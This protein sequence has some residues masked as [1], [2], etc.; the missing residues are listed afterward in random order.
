[1]VG[2]ARHLIYV[3][4]IWMAMGR[5][6]VLCRPGMSGY[7]DTVTPEAELAPARLGQTNQDRYLVRRS[8]IEQVCLAAEDFKPV[9]QMT[10]QRP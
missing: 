10:P 2:I 5:I 6:T 8:G 9:L 4:A 3:I 7:S 1:M